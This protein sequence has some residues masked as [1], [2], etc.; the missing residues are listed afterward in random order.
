MRLAS[1]LDEWQAAGLIDDSTARAIRTHEGDHH[2]PLLLWAVA[3]LG[4]FALALG[5]VL[6]VSANWQ[7]I[8]AWLKLTTHLLM[9]ATAALMLYRY[10]AR[11]RLWLGEGA[12]FLLAALVLAGIALHAQ[13]YQLTG[14]LWRALGSW[15]LLTAPVILL[16][17]RTRLTAL[18]LVAMLLGLVAAYA[19]ADTNVLG[20]NVAAGLP[21]ALIVAAL[22]LGREGHRPAF[23]QG[24]LEGGLLLT[25]GAASL[26]HILWVLDIDAGDVARNLARLPLVAVLVT[27]ACFSCFRLRPPFE[28]R[29]LAT[30][31]GGALITVLL[32]MAIPH[33]DGPFWRFFGLVSYLLLWLAIA[34]AAS[35]ADWR[36]VFGV[37]IAAL[38][39]RL[40]LVYFELFYSLAFTGLGFVIGGLLLIGLTWGWARVMRRSAA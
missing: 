33:D 2:R 37:A 11:Q 4:L 27:V 26:A 14:P 40:F 1:K 32:A 25:L 20:E 16:F 38:A 9:T 19:A 8:P 17:G 22:A 29:L 13:V 35:R 6:L 10:D 39:L 30:I 23:A 3:G 18:G 15:A 31:M 7:D 12:L 34:V 24:L 36:G 5:V 28:A 21:I